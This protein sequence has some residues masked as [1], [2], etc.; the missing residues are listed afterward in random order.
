M[1]NLHTHEF[2]DILNLL[3]KNENHRKIFGI[4]LKDWFSIREVSALYKSLAEYGDWT[5]LKLKKECREKRKKY[6]T[7]KTVFNF[8]KLIERYL[9][10]KKIK[11]VYSRESKLG[12]EH[13]YTSVTYRSRINLTKLLMDWFV[14]FTKTQKYADYTED[15]KELEYVLKELLENGENFEIRD[16]I[17]NLYDYKKGFY[18]FVSD[19][20]EILWSICIFAEKY[21]EE[22]ESYE[23]FVGKIANILVN[24]EEELDSFEIGAFKFT[25]YDLMYE[26]V[27]NK[28][29]P[30]ILAQAIEPMKV[31]H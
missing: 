29:K 24:L 23:D 12:K 18:A 14:F 30:Y 22:I 21:R 10:T 13:V 5:G 1:E 26:E 15:L 2:V 17:V 4:V 31:V 28:S 20:L 16:G 19:I 27:E 8:F 6:R 11:R 9:E 25:L 3:N 7:D